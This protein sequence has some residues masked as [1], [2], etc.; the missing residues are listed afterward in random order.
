MPR[1]S[2]PPTQPQRKLPKVK[3][4]TSR[5]TL[6]LAEV[7]KLFAQADTSTV[8]GLRD[9]EM[10]ALMLVNGL[11]EVEIVQANYGGLKEVDGIKVLVVHGRGG[12]E[13]EM[14]LRGDVRHAL[15]AYLKTRGD[16]ELFGPLFSR[17]RT[18]PDSRLKLGTATCRLHPRFGGSVPPSRLLQTYVGLCLCDY[19]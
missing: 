12:N 17:P 18:V 10:L 1:A 15:T 7:E 19:E 8:I 14:V 9:R 11:R 13:G 2:R 4:E 6:S 5:D 16:L 3:D